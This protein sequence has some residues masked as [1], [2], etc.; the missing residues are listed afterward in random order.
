MKAEIKLLVANFENMQNSINFH[1]V[2]FLKLFD[3][4]FRSG[5]PKNNAEK[6]ACLELQICENKI[7]KNSMSQNLSSSVSRTVLVR[8]VHTLV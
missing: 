2:T 8:L 6:P 4:F 5:I 3:G 7:C 1:S